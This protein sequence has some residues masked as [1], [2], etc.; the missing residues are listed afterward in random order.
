MLPRTDTLSK[1]SVLDDCLEVIA[2]P[3][4]VIMVTY[5]VA[6]AASGAVVCVEGYALCPQNN[7]TYAGDIDC[8]AVPLHSVLR[9]SVVSL[10]VYSEALGNYNHTFLF[11]FHAQSAVPQLLHDDTWNCSV[12]YYD[13]FADHLACD[14]FRDCQ[15]G[16][17][18]RDCPYVSSACGG[19]QFEAGG[20]CFGISQ[21]N[22]AGL[23]WQQAADRCTQLGGQLPVLS[24]PE[25]WQ[26]VYQLLRRK[27]FYL[28]YLGLTTVDMSL[29]QM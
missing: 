29:P 21:R 15:G 8:A 6:M 13:E 23:T 1:T 28:V 18:E 16:E 14:L 3:D 2:P 27:V 22:V 25:E 11:S 24:R 10:Y 26:A 19:R 12:T 4:Y 5:L 7:N 17:D 20:S 9:T